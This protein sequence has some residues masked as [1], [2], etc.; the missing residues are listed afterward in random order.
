MRTRIAEE[1]KQKKPFR[2]RGEEAFVSLIRTADQAARMEE[3]FL[4]QYGIT[5]TQYNVLRILRGSAPDG[6][7]CS[8][9]GRRMI[10]HVPDVTRL[11]DRMEKAGLVDRH[12]DKE[13]RRVVT[14]R[15]SAKGM[16]LVNQLDE[17][18]QG[19]DRRTIGKLGEKR[20][21]QLCELLEELRGVLE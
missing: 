11:I 17:P 3:H 2:T 5:M 13:D 15:I 20:L 16:G 8:E 9:I 10:S 19:L 6:L 21:A 4:S 1:I 12:R 7:P 14:V 18:M